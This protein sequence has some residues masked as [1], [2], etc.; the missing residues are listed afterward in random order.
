MEKSPN[1]IATELTGGCKVTGMPERLQGRSRTCWLVNNSTQISRG[2][3]MGFIIK[4][5]RTGDKDP[6]VQDEES[7]AS[8]TSRKGRSCTDQIFCSWQTSEKSETH[9]I[10]C[11]GNIM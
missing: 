2:S 1:Q 5:A 7:G 4:L 6:I 10:D 8:D 3:W 11:A 9:L